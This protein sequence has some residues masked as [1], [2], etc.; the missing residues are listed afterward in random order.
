MKEDSSLDGKALGGA[1]TRCAALTEPQILDKLS[2]KDAEMCRDAAKSFGKVQGDN[3]GVIS[4][5]T[6][7]GREDR[8]PRRPTNRRARRC[9]PSMVQASA[10]ASRPAAAAGLRPSFAPALAARRRLRSN[11]TLGFDLWQALEQ[12]L[13]RRV[14]G[15]EVEIQAALKVATVDAIRGITDWRRR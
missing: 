8:G 5:V 3:I 14:T 9:W 13:G 2:S 1:V 10:S 11:G 12:M 7:R 6:S 15:N 4:L